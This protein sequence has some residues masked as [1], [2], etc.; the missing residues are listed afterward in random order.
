MVSS[1][2]RFCIAS[3]RSS[4]CTARPSSFSSV[5][6]ER[7]A[8]ERRERVVRI[9]VRV[10]VVLFRSLRAKRSFASA[11]ARAPSP[12]T[13]SAEALD[14]DVSPSSRGI[15]RRA[16]SLGGF[17]ACRR[18]LRRGG[19]PLGRGVGR[20]ASCRA[21]APAALRASAVRL[22]AR[23]RALGRR[24]AG[25]RRRPRRRAW[26]P[27]GEAR[28]AR[29]AAARP[30]ARRRAARRAPTGSKT[31]PDASAGPNARLS[32]RRETHAWRLAMR[33]P[34]RIR[35]RACLS[36]PYVAK[37][38]KMTRACTVCFERVGAC[39]WL[40]ARRETTRDAGRLDGRT[41]TAAR[42][43]L[44]VPRAGRLLAGFQERR[45]SV[46]RRGKASIWRALEMDKAGESERSRISD[47][48]KSK[49]CALIANHH[50][51]YLGEHVTRVPTR[52]TTAWRASPSSP[53]ASPRR[54]PLPAHASAR[55][56]REAAA[57]SLS[58][59]A[60]RSVRVRATEDETDDA[61]TE[62]VEDGGSRL[63][64]DAGVRGRGFPE[65]RG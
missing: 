8:R 48:V 62:D 10:F 17:R 16:A 39:Q 18:S 57:R 55:A 49:R 5:R 14:D 43:S 52:R 27:D 7:A 60:E 40:N 23:G 53:R 37:T 56:P 3:T 9:R 1:H 31:L 19:T 29:C 46:P 64:R 2:R 51:Y 25:R 33:L 54:L 28:A 61:E 41:L 24:L 11:S 15:E 26:R 4:S 22:G 6:G 65:R 20:S 45:D 32:P 30:K 59:R 58:R 12:A 38:N 42:A 35:R 13:T 36:T 47:R 44:E 21:H 34:S 63:R 50:E